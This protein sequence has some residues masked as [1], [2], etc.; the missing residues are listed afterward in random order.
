MPARVDLVVTALERDDV[1]RPEQ[2][3]HLDLFLVAAGAVAEVHPERLVLHLVPADADAEPELAAGQHVDL[4]RLLGHEHGLALREDE[5]AG[6]QLEVGDRGEVSEQREHLVERRL[7][8][9]RAAP[10]RP[11]RHVGPDHVVV[12]HQE[13]EATLFRGASRSAR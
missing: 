10:V 12:R 5:H 8:R 3:Q 1:L 9:V 7:R 6:Y 2:P 4:R 13:G 11:G